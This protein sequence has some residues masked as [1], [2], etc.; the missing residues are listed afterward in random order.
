MSAFATFIFFTL[1]PHNSSGAYRVTEQA[2]NA[3]Y[4]GMTVGVA[5]D[6]FRTCDQLRLHLISVEERKADDAAFFRWLEADRQMQEAIRR[7]DLREKAA[8]NPGG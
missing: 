1:T 4:K 8:Q 5:V 2:C 3:C 6:M 7:R